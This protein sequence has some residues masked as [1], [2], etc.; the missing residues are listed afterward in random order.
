MC[1]RKIR[2]VSEKN[3][4]GGGQMADGLP[5]LVLRGEWVFQNAV[6][7]VSVSQGAPFAK[8]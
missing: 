7:N 5:D 2:D 6:V 1:S 4:L 3:A 8:N